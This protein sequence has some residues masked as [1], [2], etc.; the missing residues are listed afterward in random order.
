[1]ELDKV[2]IKNYRQYRDV[3]IDFAKDPEKNFT[4]IKGNN[5]TGKTTMLNALSWCL[6]GEEIHDYGDDSAMDIC[7][8]K[9]LKL[10]PNDSDIDVI[11]ELAFIDE[12]YGDLSFKRTRR[13]HKTSED[14]V[15]RPFNDVFEVKTNNNGNLEFNVDDAQYIVDTKIPQ[16]IEDYFFF[17]GARLGEYFQNTSHKKIKDAV[18]ELS[19]LNLVLSLNKNL[20][21][22]E[23]KYIKKQKKIAPDLGKAN[24]EISK[25]TSHLNVYENSMKTA[26]EKVKKL[27]TQIKDINDELMESNAND[28]E[29]KSK[30][31]NVLIEEIDRYKD[32]LNSNKEKRKNLILTN[33]PY[34]LAYSYFEDFLEYGESSR[35]KGFIPPKFKRSFI[36]DLLEQGKCICGADLEEDEAH[37]EALL[38]LL[39]ETNPLTDKSE[40]VTS[41]IAHIREVIIKR[42]KEF[43]PKLIE[44]RKNIKE[45][46]KGLD[47][48]IEERKVIKNFLDNY[49]EKHIK[50]LNKRKADYEKELDKQNRNIGRYRSEIEKINKDLGV[51]KKKLAN[52]K[53]LSAQNDEYTKKIDF[54]RKAIEAATIVRSELTE[55]MRIKIQELTKEKFIKISWKDDEFVDI[56]IDDEYGV[57]VKN[58]I[59]EEERPGDLSDGEKLCLGLCFMSALHNISGFNLPIVMDTPLGNLD[60]DMRHNIAEFLPQFVQGRQIVLLV[61]GTEYT[62]DFRN[63]LQ[64]SIGREYTIKWSNSED[65]KESEVI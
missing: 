29:E 30:R 49:S 9:S 19:Q 8:N 47:E 37:K 53:K 32:K 3:D 63:T 4:I 16:D 52:E 46:E 59:G 22:V 55:N 28:V 41:A 39:D 15:T 33:Y 56:R 23:E 43:K 27:K 34:V 12:D 6:Y 45:Y 20:S 50:Q 40:E 57:Y 60:V 5:G 54:C 35:Q 13:F 10:A 58:R 62:E 18:L 48:R 26:K 17:D 7:N 51:W 61:T 64:D 21:N 1:M 31:D 25:L 44:I 36:E 2:I 14:L 42:I 24:D 38:K 65:G 11:V